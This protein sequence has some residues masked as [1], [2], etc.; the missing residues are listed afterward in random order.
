MAQEMGE[1]SD[2]IFDEYKGMYEKHGNRIFYVLKTYRVKHVNNSMVEIITAFLVYSKNG[3]KIVTRNMISFLIN[4]KN[5]GN[6]M[7][8]LHKLGDFKVI[9]VIREPMSKSDSGTSYRFLL[10]NEF[11]RHIGN[12][13]EWK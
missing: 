9:T 2:R 11:L 10:T 1:L 4:L 7:I 6:M 13:E 8:K 12:Y 5:E 3:L